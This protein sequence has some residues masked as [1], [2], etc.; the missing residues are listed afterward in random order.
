M[1]SAAEAQILTTHPKVEDVKLNP[2]KFPQ[3]ESIFS[4][5][6]RKDVAFQQT[7]IYCCF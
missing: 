7:K 5:K 6:F 3:P 4:L 1:M 2:E